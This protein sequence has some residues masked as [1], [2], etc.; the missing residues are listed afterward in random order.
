MRKR[1]AN[2]GLIAIAFAVGLLV[3]CF[4]SARFLIAVLAF[5]VILLGVSFVRCR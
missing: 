5:A 4:A 1:T 3:A 2:K